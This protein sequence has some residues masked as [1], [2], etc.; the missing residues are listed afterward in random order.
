MMQDNSGALFKNRNKSSEKHADYTGSINIDGKP[1]WLNAWVNESQN[2]VRYMRLMARPKAADEAS[3]SKQPTAELTTE[4]PLPA[5]NGSPF[6]DD[7]P[8]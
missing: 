2:G 3:R 1:F 5:K 8:F 4:L 7:L 6:N